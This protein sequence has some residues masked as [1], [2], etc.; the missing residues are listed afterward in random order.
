MLFLSELLVLAVDIAAEKRIMTA[1]AF[2]KLTD[3]QSVLKRL[4]V[5][6]IC[7]V[8]QSLAVKLAVLL[9]LLE[10]I[11][12]KPAFED[13]HL[14]DFCSNLWNCV[15]SVH[16]VLAAR[17]LHEVESNTLCT[18]AVAKE[19]SKAVSVEDVPAI[20]LQAGLVSQ[21][22]AADVAVVKLSDLVARSA[23]DLEAGQMIVIVLSFAAAAGVAAIMLMSTGTDLSNRL[24]LGDSAALSIH[25]R[26]ELS[27]LLSV[28]EV[29]L[30]ACTVDTNEISEFNHLLFCVFFCL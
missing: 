11:L 26:E 3:V 18:P 30:C 13:A 16:I 29:F 15:K 20:E 9:Q 17:A 19:L 7:W 24:E 28:D 22:T 12:A 21:G 5:E 4:V 2:I 1:R 14:S 6:S 27:F 10:S 8:F 25:H 23:L